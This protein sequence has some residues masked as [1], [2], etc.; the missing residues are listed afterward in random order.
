MKVEVQHGNVGDIDIPLGISVSV[1]V[2]LYDLPTHQNQFV[3]IEYKNT[4]G[5]KKV[6]VI[7]QPRWL[8][9]NLEPRY[10]RVTKAK[11]SKGRYMLLPSNAFAETKKYMNKWLSEALQATI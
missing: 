3:N 1:K 11:H 7:P 8:Q 2:S 6:I 5:T 10:I 9:S 4:N